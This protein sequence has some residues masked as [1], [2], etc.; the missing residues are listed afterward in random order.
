MWAVVFDRVR[1][2]KKKSK[3]KMKWEM[4]RRGRKT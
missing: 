3:D 1:H 4:R 2:T